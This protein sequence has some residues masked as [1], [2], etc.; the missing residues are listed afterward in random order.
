[1]KISFPLEKES[2][3]YLKGVVVYCKPPSNGITKSQPGMGI[4][5]TEFDET[6]RRILMSLARGAGE[7]GLAEVEGGVVMEPSHANY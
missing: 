4:K 1:L 3:I 6:A 5:F 7:R 2:R